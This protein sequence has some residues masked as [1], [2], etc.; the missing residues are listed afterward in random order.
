MRGGGGGGGGGMVMGYGKEY[1]LI[2]LYLSFAGLG[3]YRKPKF[4]PTAKDPKVHSNSVSTLYI[5]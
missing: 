3:H 2:F 4:H 5:S 1:W